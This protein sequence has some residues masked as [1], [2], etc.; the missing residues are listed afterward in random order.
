MG[1]VY[2]KGPEAMSSWGHFFLGGHVFQG[3]HFNWYVD[4]YIKVTPYI[5]FIQVL[6][7]TEIP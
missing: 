1:M 6:E 7:V 5:Y 2:L 4:L 3:G